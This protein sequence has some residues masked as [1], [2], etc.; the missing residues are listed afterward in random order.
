MLVGV[1]GP[2]NMAEVQL[3]VGAVQILG[4]V[5]CA[6]LTKYICVFTFRQISNILQVDVDYSYI[7]V[8]KLLVSEHIKEIVQT[9]PMTVQIR[10]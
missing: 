4:A 6:L 3:F 7:A 2:A 5:Y 1:S 9:V 10:S 8:T